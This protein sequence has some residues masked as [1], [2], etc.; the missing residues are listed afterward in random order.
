M[1]LW[2]RHWCWLSVVVALNIFPIRDQISVLHAYHLI[3]FAAQEAIL[4]YIGTA[5][6]VEENHVFVDLGIA[7][8]HLYN[9]HPRT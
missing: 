7:F 6:S 1:Y 3:V 9:H 8:E 5:L 4:L 2:A